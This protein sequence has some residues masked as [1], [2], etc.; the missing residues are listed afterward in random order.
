[1]PRIKR[2]YRFGPYRIVEALPELQRDGATEAWLSQLTGGRQVVLKIL[3]VSNKDLDEEDQRAYAV[4]RKEVELLKTLRHL[5]IVRIYPLHPQV[6]FFRDECYLSKSVFQDETWWFWAME[7]L[8]GGSLSDR[9]QEVGRLPLEEAAEIAYQLG[10][11][12][13]YIHSKA[14]VHLNVH[15]TNIFFRYPISVL[16]KRVEA[17]LTD[18]SA[19]IRA[20]AEVQ[21]SGFKPYM[22]PERIKPQQVSADQ[23]IDHRPM[24]VYALGALLYEMLAGNPPFVGDDDEDLERAILET[25]P[26]PL[27][28]FDVPPE[29]EALIFQALQKD[30]AQRPSVEE[31]MTTLDKSIPPPRM[32]GRRLAVPVVERTITTEATQPYTAPSRPPDVLTVETP[33]RP[34]RSF[35][36]PLLTLG[37]FIPILGRSKLYPAPKLLEPGEGAILSGEVTFTWSWEGELKD[38]E[39]FELRIWKEGRHDRAGELQKEP[40]LE[41]DLDALVP[42]LPGE[43]NECF[44]SVAVVQEN[45]YRSLSKEA[46]PRSFIY[47]GLLAEEEAGPAV[48][49]DVEAEGRIEAEVYGE[50]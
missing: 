13:D 11:A 3:R 36:S 8:R 43:S 20:D 18:F 14:I 37:R 7:Y 45:P 46:Q 25:A 50:D 2:G 4:F 19:A 47:G 38:N 10:A 41:I 33:A 48:G 1:M 28:R 30:P 42:E 27:Q 21:D 5:N 49:V 16:D 34:S 12:L 9:I 35:F 44:W 23:L 17:V 24:D 39:A 31:I 22:P 29:I 15:P 32:V 40:A 26:P 6:I